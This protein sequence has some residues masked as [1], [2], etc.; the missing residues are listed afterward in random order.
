MLL[1]LELTLLLGVS[2]LAVEHLKPRQCYADL[3]IVG[4]QEGICGG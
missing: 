1:T 2:I 3:I 4:L